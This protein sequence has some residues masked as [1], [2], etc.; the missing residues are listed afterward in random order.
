[1][2][3]WGTG[4]FVIVLCLLVCAG[5]LPD[6]SLAVDGVVGGHSIL[7]DTSQS[8]KR[9]FEA[10]KQR[11][12]RRAFA[13]LQVGSAPAVVSPEDLQMMLGP[14]GPAVDPDEEDLD[15]IEI[16]ARLYPG[17][18]E[19][20]TQAEIPYGFAGIAWS[21]RHPQQAWRLFLP[22]LESRSPS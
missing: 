9:Q 5:S 18:S 4:G 20:S 8:I 14:E 13:G 11:R 1:M 16:E 10:A 6:E 15:N 22:V 17:T 21:L 2:Q 12:V 7:L 19:S 3:R